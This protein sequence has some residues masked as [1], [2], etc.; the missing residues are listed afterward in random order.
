MAPEES[1]YLN[2]SLENDYGLGRRESNVNFDSHNS[3]H[4]SKLK[5]I[6]NDISNI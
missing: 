1:K 5:Q 4:K 3:A 2:T 6:M